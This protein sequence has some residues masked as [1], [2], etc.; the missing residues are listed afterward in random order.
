M[1]TYEMAFG[2]V[3]AALFLALVFIEEAMRRQVHHARYGNQ[4]VSPWS[5]RYV[6]EFFGQYGVWNLHRRLYERSGVRLWFWAVLV[7]FFVCLA[8]AACGY[9]YLR[10]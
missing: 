6:N 9:V 1:R 4:E 2:A 10:R 3:L 5:V 8:L 7:A